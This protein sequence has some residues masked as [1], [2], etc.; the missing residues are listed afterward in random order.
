MTRHSRRLIVGSAGGTNA[1]GTLESMRER[2]GD[3]VF[4]IAIDTGTRELTAAS[5]LADAFV[6]VPLARAPEFHGALRDLAA[7]YPDS[8]YL[9]LHDEEIEVAARLAAEGDLPPGLQL[10]APPFDV[11]RLC[12]DKW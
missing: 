4:L 12:N 5:V 2:Y 1:F 7:S 6:R 11:V 3:A 8:Y 10:I 9:P